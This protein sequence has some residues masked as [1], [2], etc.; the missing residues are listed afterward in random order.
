MYFFP[1]LFYADQAKKD[2]KKKEDS[3]NK[4]SADL[5]SVKHELSVQERITNSS[6]SNNKRY[7]SVLMETQGLLNTL[8]GKVNAV[9]NEDSKSKLDKVIKKEVTSD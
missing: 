9:L 8:S 6:E 4:L 3:Y 7:L 2:L 5:K 1:L